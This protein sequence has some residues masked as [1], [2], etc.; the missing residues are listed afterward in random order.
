MQRIVASVLLLAVSHPLFALDV[1]RENVQLFIEEMVDEHEFD[2]DELTSVLAE[3]ELKQSIIDAISSPA[4]KKLTWA[5]YRDIFLTEERIAA[6]AE[7]WKE[8]SEMLARI[9]DETGVPETI[10]VG[11]IGVETYYGRITGSFRV[12]DA[13][14][15]LAFHY[16]PRSG[17]FRKE[18]GEFLLLSREEGMHATEATGSYAGAMGRPQFMPSSFRAYA[19]D[20]T[21]DGK[22][23]IWEDWAD[24]AGSIANYFNEHGWRSGEETVARATLGS[25]WSGPAPEPANTLKPE[26][27]VSSLS[28]QGVIF[29]TDQDGGDA[30]EL[31]ALDGEDGREFW[32]AFHNF[33]VITRYNRSVMYALAVHQLGEAVARETERNAG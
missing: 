2:R 13:L 30:A 23:D 7:F 31:L 29:A 9:A 21:G 26:A 1:T 25:A 5:E 22:R 33:F 12:L 11:I 6:G 8:H 24:V 4:E 19:V 15:T 17:F 3:A 27:T 32:V 28:D 18:L 20:S 16:P 14:A 10:L